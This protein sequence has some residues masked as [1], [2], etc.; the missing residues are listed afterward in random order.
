V[1]HRYPAERI[2][3]MLGD[4]GVALTLT[5]RGLAPEVLGC[6]A[7]PVFIEDAEAAAPEASSNLGVNIKPSFAAYVM[8]TS[9]TSGEPKGAAIPH[10]GIARLVRRANYIRLDAADVVLHHSTC[11]FDAATFEMWAALL[12]GAALVLYPPRPFDLDTL[13][14]V[15]RDYGVTTLLLTTSV[16]HL[17]AEHKPECLATLTNVVTG[18]DVL[19][20]K[21]VKKVI[22]RY[23]HL[24]IV[25]GYG[26]TENT[27]FTCCYVIT[28][29]T[30]LGET[31]PLGKPV[32]GTNVFILDENMRRVGAASRRFQTSSTACRQSPAV[33]V[34][35]AP[36][37]GP[38]RGPPARL[39]L[40]ILPFG[41]S[42]NSSTR[43]TC[44]GTM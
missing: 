30:D 12:N 27:V 24:K 34:A 28:S 3:F 29:E 5:S 26:P 2:R 11:S 37:P 14:S 9:G 33:G 18:G 36:G 39:F 1:D 41:V 20:A 6:L 13:A 15:I 31:V 17:V 22:G 32:D 23:P 43:W 4:T 25:N 38:S 40:S 19:R 35:T 21:A 44:A 16:F 7:R 42:G 10:S 8:Y